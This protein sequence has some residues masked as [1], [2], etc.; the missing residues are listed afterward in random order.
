MLEGKPLVQHHHQP[1]KTFPDPS[2]IHIY[3]RTESRNASQ[4]IVG[5]WME[6]ICPRRILRGRMVWIGLDRF[7]GNCLLL[8][9]TQKCLYRYTMINHDKPTVQTKN[10]SLHIPIGPWGPSLNAA[11]LLGCGHR[12]G[13]WSWIPADT[14]ALS[15]ALPL[16][17]WESLQ[18]TTSGS[19]KGL[20][21]QKSNL[22][23]EDIGRPGLVE[24][25]IK[26]YRNYNMCLWGSAGIHSDFHQTSS[27]H[28]ITSTN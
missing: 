5:M 8:M 9:G 21:W 7:F 11:G 28:A 20:K 22:G 19:C 3:R 1:S 27:N 14:T 13:T 17:Q 16:G 23:L 25:S 2:W 15:L 10:Q 18:V 24:R 26:F 12:W 4:F 6:T